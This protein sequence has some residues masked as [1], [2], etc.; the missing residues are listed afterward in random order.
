MATY[1]MLS[2]LTDRGAETI[3]TTLSTEPWFA[4]IVEK[5]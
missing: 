5:A 1:I 3:N 4:K 2:R